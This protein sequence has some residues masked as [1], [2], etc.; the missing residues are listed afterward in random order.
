M[1][2]L[3]LVPQFDL[4]ICYEKGVTGWDGGGG[5]F[6]ARGSSARW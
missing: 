1:R 5:E 4:D 2:K 3:V 6:Y